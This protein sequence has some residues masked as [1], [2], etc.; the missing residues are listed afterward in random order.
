VFK[1]IKERLAI[2]RWQKSTLGDALQRHGHEY[3]WAEGAVFADFGEQDKLENCARLHGEAMTIMNSSDPFLAA[4]ERLADY[5]LTFAPLMAAG[6]PEEGK[7]ER[8]YADTPYIS[9][10]LR[11]HISKIAEHIDE[12]GR[13]RFD[14]PDISDE[15]LA[16]YCTTRAT[17]LLFMCNGLNLVSIYLEDR[18]H[19]QSEWYKAFVQAALVSAEDA[20]RRDIGLDPLLPSSVDGLVYSSF[21]NYVVNG[22]PDPFYAWTKAFPDNYLLGKGSLPA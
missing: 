7:E 4:R 3:F 6:M 2:R 21:M 5:V 12:L 17:V 9:G 11:P 10:K 13:L 8:G 16:N 22:E 15:E 20:I 19:S 18:V 1:A 14:D